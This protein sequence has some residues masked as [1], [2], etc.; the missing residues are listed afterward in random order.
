MFSFLPELL[1]SDILYCYYSHK[2]KK[3][4][5][6]GVNLWITF[7]QIYPLALMFIIFVAVIYVLA[8]ILINKSKNKSLLFN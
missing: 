3:I 6:K 1:K 5:R 2:S 7:T 4:N 8:K